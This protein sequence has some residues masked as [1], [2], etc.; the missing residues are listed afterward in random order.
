MIVHAL[1]GWP[2][3]L[4]ATLNTA[5][6]LFAENGDC[7]DE[8]SQVQLALVGAQVAEFALLHRHAVVA[9]EAL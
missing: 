4:G 6:T 7:L 8:R 9:A 1:R 3:P 5:R 2:T